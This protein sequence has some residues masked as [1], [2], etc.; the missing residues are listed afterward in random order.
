MTTEQ[1]TDI[2]P[3]ITEDKTA[4][5]TTASNKA[6]FGPLGKYAVIAVIMVSIIVTTAIMLDKELTTV[7]DQVAVLDENV[8]ELV[9]ADAEAI[10]VEEMPAAEVSTVETQET[11]VTASAEETTAV[12]E[13]SAEVLIATQTA[14][15]TA[16]TESGAATSETAT[17]ENTPQD[18]KNQLEKEYLARIET[19]KA[20]QKQRMTEM[21]SRIKTLE[22]QQLE[23]YKTRQDAQVEHLRE[24]IA[25]QQAMIDTLISRN[26]ELY[27]LRAA[28]TEQH[29]SK[30]EEMLN[31]I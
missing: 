4:E 17:A 23:Q 13:P 22:E 26:K 14:P 31:R 3:E 20:E 16:V 12:V 6:V 19:V 29:Q 1:K 2:T 11:V 30:R 24:Q 25:K 21:F 7:E 5:T 8:V 18:R 28:R 15:E 10:A 27:E 9:V